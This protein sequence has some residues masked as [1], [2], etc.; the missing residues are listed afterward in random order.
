MSEKNR[1]LFIGL[2][3]GFLG[4]VVIAVLVYWLLLPS[5]VQ[6]LKL[7]TGGTGG[8]YHAFGKAIA[9]VVNKNSKLIRI[10]HQASGG[11][12]R[13]AELIAQG[14]AQLGF[15]QS[16]TELKNNVKIA[17]QLYPEVFHLIARTD[18]QI[19]SVKDLVGKRVALPGKTSGSAAVFDILRK[20][21]EL[22]VGDMA[23]QHAPLNEG[24]EALKKGQVDALFVVIAQGNQKLRSLIRDADVELVSIDQSDAIAQ[25]LP[26]FRAG[27]IPVGAYSGGKPIPA[28]AIDVIIVDSLLA[29][30]DSLRNS[31]AKELVRILI[32]KRQQVARL[33]SQ[34]VHIQQPQSAHN[35]HEGARLFY[36]KD[37]PPFI[38]EYAEPMA[39]VM[40]VVLL[41]LSSIWQARTWLS[42]NRKNRADHYNLD[43]IDLTK[44]IHKAQSSDELDDIRGEL[45]AIFQKVMIDLDKDKIEEKSL[46]SFSFAWDVASSSLNHR[47]I[48]LS[49][50]GD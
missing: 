4:L 41:L 10:E 3:T 45:F 13:N 21:Y 8:T 34:G 19:K 29:V 14:D 35:I 37:E 1:N 47:Q 15:V 44:R 43:L 11:S 27:R 39:F 20:H 22:R 38:V 18:A 31:H 25:S 5:R 23:L 24:I 16:D 6:T 42:K 28:Q 46:Q 26:A 17:V 32:E 33:I 40:S 2:L 48:V 30:Q 49:S 9:E 7:V 50:N 12:N 36:T